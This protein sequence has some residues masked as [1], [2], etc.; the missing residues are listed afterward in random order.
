[1][2]TTHTTSQ[3]QPLQ[4]ELPMDHTPA[5]EL[6]MR[7]FY[8]SRWRRW[9]PAG[10]FDVAVQDPVTKRCIALAVQHLPHNTT[11]NRK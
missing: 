3:K 8:D 10:S 4:P 11:G 2:H 1:M 9:H 6:Q 7:A 5:L